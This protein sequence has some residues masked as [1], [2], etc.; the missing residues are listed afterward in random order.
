MPLAGS[1][2]RQSSSSKKTVR[3]SRPFSLRRSTSCS[4]RMK[5]PR[6]SA[7]GPRPLVRRCCRWSRERTVCC[8][9]PCSTR[10]SKRQR[11]STTRVRRPTSRSSRRWTSW[12][13]RVSRRCSWRGLTT[14]S[15]ALRTKSLSSTQRCLVSK[16]S[17]RNTY[18]S[19]AMIGR[20]RSPRSLKRSQTSCSTPSTV[21]PTWASSR[22]TRR[23]ASA[24]TTDHLGVDRGRRGA[25]NG[26][27]P[28]WPVRRLELLP[29]R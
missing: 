13:R 23:P 27:R 24:R 29:E 14:C 6:C 7:V 4:L 18:R 9:T 25:S 12:R 20:H 5:S 11:T 17:A 22:R 19:I 1:L 16:S 26:C 21:R 8:F 10:V 2:E 3:A 28:H 15:R